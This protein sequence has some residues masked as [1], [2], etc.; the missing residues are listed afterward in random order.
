[1]NFLDTVIR[2]ADEISA[3]IRPLINDL[4]C[5]FFFS[6]TAGSGEGYSTSEGD[7]ASSEPVGV[8]V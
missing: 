4:F 7:G 6:V 8:W 5:Y 1:M 2:V 3:A